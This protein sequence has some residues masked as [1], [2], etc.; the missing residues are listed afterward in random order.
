MSRKLSGFVKSKRTKTQAAGDEIREK[1][2]L[3]LRR[4]SYELQY[5][6][7]CRLGRRMGPSPAAGIG[8]V[9]GGRG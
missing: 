7:I 5:D 3:F 9:Q 2:R 6:A 1:C 4:P 8:Y